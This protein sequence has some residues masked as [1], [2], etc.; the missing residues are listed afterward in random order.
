MTRYEYKSKIVTV[1]RESR[2][3]YYDNNGEPKELAP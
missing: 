2:I 3:Y 1:S